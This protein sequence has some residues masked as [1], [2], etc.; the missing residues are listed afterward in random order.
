MKATHIQTAIDALERWDGFTDDSVE[1][2]TE[3]EITT[4]AARLPGGHIPDAYRELLA[5]GGRKLGGV[6]SGIDISVEMTW[7]LLSNDYMDIK[8]MMRPWNNGATLP[9][10]LFVLNEHFG[11]NFTFVRLDEGNDPPVYFWKEGGGLETARREHDTFSAFLLDLVQKHI[12][13]GHDRTRLQ[14]STSSMT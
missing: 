2:C 1:P 14:E 7:T 6:Y 11:S 4:M 5:Y 8:A 9:S 10:E 3:Q 12:R 13:L